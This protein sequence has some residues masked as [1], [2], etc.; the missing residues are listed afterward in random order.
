M[1]HF[2]HVRITRRHSLHAAAWPVRAV[3]NLWL[4]TEEGPVLHWWEETEARVHRTRTPAGLANTLRQRLL[5]ARLD[6][7]LAF[8]PAH[9]LAC[10]HDLCADLIKLTESL[11][12][13]A[14]GDRAALR[15]HAMALTRWARYASAWVQI[16]GPGFNQ[17]VDGLDLEPDRLAGRESLPMEV[18][19]AGAP[20]EQPKLDGRYQFWHLLYERLDLKL[21][22][23]GVEE[24]ARRSLARSLSRIYEQC[25]IT[26]RQIAGLEK[27]INP[28]FGAVSRLL[29]DINTAWH[30]DLGPYHLGY[31]ELRVRGASTPGLQQLLFLALA[32]PMGR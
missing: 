9:D 19:P 25:L 5:A 7:D 16:S 30:F 27:E 2:I 11:L 6:E 20:E 3:G 10:L 13:S 17:L 12:E 15:R 18:P 31:G 22:A 21:E 1:A 32:E 8:G 23:A 26:F 14:T 4:Q 28:R 29:L 24:K